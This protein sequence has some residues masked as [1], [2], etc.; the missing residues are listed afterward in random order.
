TIRFL[1]T[2][3]VATLA[4]SSIAC[5]P[6][7]PPR[8]ATAHTMSAKMDRPGAPVAK[9]GI[10]ATDIESM[11]KR[12]TTTPLKDFRVRA[13]DGA[14][15]LHVKAVAAPTVKSKKRENGTS[16]TI[17]TFSI[18]SDAEVVCNASSSPLDIGHWAEDIVVATKI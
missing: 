6:P 16:Y 8:R 15:E 12:E 1:A 13:G 5:A 18:G 4:L 14:L 9:N 3:L 2:G 17:A 10:A 11:L 7:P